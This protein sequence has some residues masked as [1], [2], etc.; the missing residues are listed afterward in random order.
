MNKTMTTFV[1]ILALCGVSLGQAEKPS[2]KDVLRVTSQ[3]LITLSE[4]EASLDHIR[5]RTTAEGSRDEV[6]K[7]V[8]KFGKLDGERKALGTPP[9]ETPDAEKLEME[10]RIKSRAISG[11]DQRMSFKFMVPVDSSWKGS[12]DGVQKIEAASD[13]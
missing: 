13:Y 4:I 11:E 5:D 3:I 10:F 6:I 7:L 9:L 1:L 2:G 12:W 8:E